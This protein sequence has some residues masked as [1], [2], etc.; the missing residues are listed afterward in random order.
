V[1]INA[2]ISPKDW[3][4]AENKPHPEWFRGWFR[5]GVHRFD[6]GVF[7]E[8]SALARLLISPGYLHHGRAF[9]DRDSIFHT[10]AIKVYPLEA[11]GKRAD[12]LEA[13]HFTRHVQQ[14]RDELVVMAENGSF[15][16]VIAILGE[17]FWERAWSTFTA[18]DFGPLKVRR[19]Q[20]AAAATVHHANRVTL[21]SRTDS[22]DLALVR[23]S[24]VC[25]DEDRLSEVAE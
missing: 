16:H 17:P 25:E 14:W 7:R 19:Y 18:G 20:P 13:H 11:E 4:P 8:A 6:K 2:Y 21:D 12:Q 10:D 1:G 9:R 3:V 5:D 24:S 23:P 15:P 22:H